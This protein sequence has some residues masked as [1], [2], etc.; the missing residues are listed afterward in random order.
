MRVLTEDAVLYCLHVP[1]RVGL[2]PRQSWVTIAKRRVLVAKDPEGRP[3]S[4]ACWNVV[5]PNVPCTRTLPVITGYSTFIRVD[6][7]ELCLDTVTGL[8]NGTLQGT[9]RYSVAD[10]GQTFISASA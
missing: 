5:T 8:T 9:V 4:S 6:G 7:H 2:D 1:G 3:I 10:P